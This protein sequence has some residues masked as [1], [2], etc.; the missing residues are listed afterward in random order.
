MPPRPAP[1]FVLRPATIADYR[2][3]WELKRAT[4][5]TYVEQTWGYW[6]D[7]AQ[8]DFFRRSFN[9]SPV[10]VIMSDGVDA[11]LLH[12]EREPRELFL[13]NIQIAPASQ[14]RGLGTAVVQSVL[15]SA[16]ALRLPVRLQVLRVNTAA[17]RLYERLG[18]A[19]V[20]QTPT[21]FILRHA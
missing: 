5:R 11:G 9:L 1:A 13:A 8:E 2:W 21:H 19:L 18:F 17:R 6:D 14:N 10:E 3:L 7:A 20:A 4:M 16:R 15:A 12:V